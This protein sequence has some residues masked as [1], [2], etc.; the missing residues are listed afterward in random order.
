[1]ITPKFSID[2]TSGTLDP[3]I[4]FAR[5]GNTATVTNQNEAIVLANAD[6]PRFDYAA[7]VSS[8]SSCGI[9]SG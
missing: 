6:T 7:P 2:F 1:M 8:R 3:R 9:A 5:S 4:T